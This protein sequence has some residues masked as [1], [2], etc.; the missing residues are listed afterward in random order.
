MEEEVKTQVLVIMCMH[1][2][3]SVCLCVCNIRAH[4]KGFEQEE[5]QYN[6]VIAVNFCL[7]TAG[8]VP[9]SCLV[10]IQ[11]I[12]PFIQVHITLSNM[13]FFPI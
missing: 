7:T 11:N 9:C 2:C 1:M 12:H 4:M 13:G 10:F 6:N 8:H 3:V 5:K